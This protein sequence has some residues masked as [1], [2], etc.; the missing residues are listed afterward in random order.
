[1]NLN[2][3]KICFIGAGNMAHAIVGG[4]VKKGLNASNI[5]AT[6][7]NLEHREAMQNTWQVEVDEDNAR[8]VSTADIVVLSV[9][10]QVLQ[11]VCESLKGS[12]SHRP[13]IISIAAGI[14]LDLL[15]QWL[16]SEQ[17]LVRCMPNTPAQVLKGAS[18]LIANANV[19]DE[20]K[21][22]SDELFQAIGL[23]EWVDQESLI[24]S[25]TAL[26][27]SGPA[28]IF[29]M[30]EA[31]EAAA[32]KQGL[33]ADTARKL[34]AQTVAGAAEMVLSGDVAPAQLKRN[35]MSPGGTTERAIHTFEEKGLL[36]IVDEAMQ[37]AADRSVSLAEEL[38]A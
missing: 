11:S 22:L 13:L 31:M 15:A 34:A 18:G 36:E 32:I 21:N 26:S 1:M 8:A 23:V 24:H 27:G 19:S 6:A 35:V 14:G 20:Q 7:P 4:L 28:Y 30:I 9:K 38:K 2:E 12:L 17:A 16:G 3:Q 10:P 33:S 37:A 29:L 25:V 5:V